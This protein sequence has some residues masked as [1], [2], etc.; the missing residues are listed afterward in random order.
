VIRLALVLSVALLASCGPAGQTASVV[1]F[2]VTDVGV[3]SLGNNVFFPASLLAHPDWRNE[4][5]AEIDSAMAANPSERYFGIAFY[6]C[7][8]N[9]QLQ[10]PSSTDFGTVVS[11]TESVFIPTEWTVYLSWSMA[12]PSAVTG[13]KYFTVG[14]IPYEL[15]NCRCLCESG[16]H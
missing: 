7:D 1:P 6:V 13:Q 15:A 12:G 2:Q 16:L 14:N 3:T 11:S 4:T 10:D 5:V 8:D 9:V